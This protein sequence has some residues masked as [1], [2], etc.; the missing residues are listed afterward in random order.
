MR[1]ARRPRGPLSVGLTGLAILISIVFLMPI[2]WLLAS[3]FRSAAETFA[4]S[5][6]ISL[7]T[8]WPRHW[9]FANVR[10]AI[11]S[12][13]LVNLGNSL[14]VAG[15]TVVVGL[16]FSAMAGFA[17]AVL[18]FKGRQTL[19]AVVVLSFLV[20]FEAIAIPLS[21]SFHNWGLANTYLALILPGLG[22]GLAVFS[23]RQFFLGVPYALAEAARVDGASWWRIFWS[24][25]LPLCRPVLIGA[26]L[27]LFLFQWQAYMWPIL[28]VSQDNLDLAPVSIAKAFG[29]FSTDYGRVFVETAVLA[30]VPAA[31][32]LTLQRHFVSSLAS[33][34]GKE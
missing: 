3:S 27:M 7:W 1:E 33:T 15:V 31:I 13:F 4:D 23:L 17:L 25:Y 30:L 21:R 34:G 24:I 10:S 22:N 29:A 8:I 6:P 5:S 2:L 26:G 20:P 11:D 12:G 9:T 14:L 32:L 28:V 16:L 19:F 18:P